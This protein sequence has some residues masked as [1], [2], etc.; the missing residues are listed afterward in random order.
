MAVNLDAPRRAIRA[1]R[2]HLAER[3]GA[4]INLSSLAALEPYPHF[5]SYGVSKLALE[6]LTVDVAR[7]LAPA[8]VAV[9]CLRIDVAVASEGF[10]A[11]SPGAD[12][13]TWEPCEVAA[14]GL[15]W[16]LRQPPSYTGRLESMWHLRR[17]EGIMR[18]RAAVQIETPPPITHFGDLSA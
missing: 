12:L 13:S 18:S 1:A 17:R 11:N 16:M 8:G 2:P 10:V 15:L 3:G 9:N 7:Q 4:V 5:M 14:E 6:R